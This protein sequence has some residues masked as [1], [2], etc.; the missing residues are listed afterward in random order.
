MKK[1][2]I[3]ASG[4]VIIIALFFIVPN[5]VRSYFFTLFQSSA[6]DN[7]EF[8]SIQNSI[9]SAVMVTLDEYDIIEEWISSES[10]PEEQQQNLIIK[11]VRVPGDLHLEI[12]NLALTKSIQAMGYSVLDG[13]E[14]PDR[15]KVIL[16]AGVNTIPSIRIELTK[17]NSLKYKKGKI[18]LILEDF[19]A[20]YDENTV[21]FLSLPFKV[22]ISIV[23]GRKYSKKISD[24]A[25][26][27][28]KEVIINLPMESKNVM[29]EK[30]NY[31]LINTMTRTQMSSLMN[32][33]FTELP[34]AKGLNN[35]SGSLATENVTLMRNLALILRRK[36]LYFVDNITS[37]KSKAFDTMSQ[38]RVKT[39]KRNIILDM[40]PV[41]ERILYQFELL[42]EFAKQDGMAIGIGKESS[43]TLEIL[44]TELPKLTKKGYEF[45]FVS[46]LF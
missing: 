22:S 8:L 44:K 26:Q 38:L 31:L 19:G 13:Q 2:S 21:E 16:I 30:E 20:K 24:D 46:E 12:L 1:Y 4:A 35:Y 45:S 23:P 33:V 32:S 6:I 39:K 14:I 7:E 11:K 3:I 9:E 18:A 15:G 10:S 27:E 36:G 41:R 5:P 43:L 42:K 25:V 34:G 29:G 37:T 28:N 40:E 17:N